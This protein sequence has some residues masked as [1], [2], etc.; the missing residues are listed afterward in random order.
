M[1]S[2]ELSKL[3]SSLKRSG[4]GQ[5]KELKFAKVLLEMINKYGKQVLRS[6]CNNINWCVFIFYA[7]KLKTFFQYEL[8][9]DIYSKIQRFTQTKVQNELHICIHI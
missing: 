2:E 6:Y 8:T 4:I 5:I 9:T 7:D 3:V 1:D